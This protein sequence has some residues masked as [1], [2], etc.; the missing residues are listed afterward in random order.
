MELSEYVRSIYTSPAYRFD[1]KEQRGGF[2]TYA[3]MRYTYNVLFSNKITNRVWLG[4]Y[5]EASNEEFMV[6]NHIRVVINCSKDIPFYFDSKAIPYQYRIPVDD[7]RQPESMAIMY[8]YLPEIVRLMR[9]HVLRG[10]N[11]Y[12]HCHAGMQR[13]ACVVVCYLLS[14]C[15]MNVDEAIAFVK[16]KR[17]I[18]FTPFVNFRP[19]INAYYQNIVKDSQNVVVRSNDCRKK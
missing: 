5:I 15:S 18:A 9:E 7:D 4:N 3:Y 10:H 1:R 6:R 2:L 16:H 11:I 13:S 8:S 14:M 12:V 17:P 19:S